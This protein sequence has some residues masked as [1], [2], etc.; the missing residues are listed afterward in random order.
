MR[1]GAY[2]LI[3]AIIKTHPDFQCEIILN[4]GVKLTE[5][6]KERINEVKFQLLESFKNLII[7][8]FPNTN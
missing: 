4:Y 2:K 3:N 7:T 5:R 8:S 6:F 1:R